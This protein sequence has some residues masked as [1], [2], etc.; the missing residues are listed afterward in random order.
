MRHGRTLDEMRVFQSLLAQCTLER[1]RVGGGRG[2]RSVGQWHRRRHERHGGRTGVHG[3]A[4]AAAAG[5]AVGTGGQRGRVQRGTVGGAVASGAGRG[6]TTRAIHAGTGC[7]G[8]SAVGL[9]RRH[10]CGAHV[11]ATRR[12]TSAG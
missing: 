2:R 6:T 5:C 4:A 1:G 7:T 10:R 8:G 3:R 11:P 12:S 9:A